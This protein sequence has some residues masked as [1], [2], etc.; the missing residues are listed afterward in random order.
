MIETILTAAAG[1]AMA[2]TPAAVL[3]RQAQE[4]VRELGQAYELAR[5]DAMHDGLTGLANRRAF[6]GHAAMAVATVSPDRPLA[7][8]V[9]DIDAFKAINDTFGHGVGDLVLLSA[10]HELA[11]RVPHGLVARLG[12]DEFVVLVELRGGESAEDVG[13]AL[14]E[15]SDAVSVDDDRVVVTFSVGVAEVRAP[16]DLTAVLACA[17]A[18][19][20]RAKQGNGVA[21]FHP[22]RDDHSAPV[23]RQRQ[24]VRTRD[25][26]VWLTDEQIGA[27]R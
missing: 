5:Y 25:L 6:Y 22:V 7:V 15:A 1:A 11:G 27:S 18:A 9:I 4:R 20:Y 17:D 16:A 26:P 2:V 19:M 10:A 13:A 8:A 3:L 24:A 21:V 14:A 12:G 23:P